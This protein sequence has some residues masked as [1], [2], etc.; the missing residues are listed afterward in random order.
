MWLCSHFSYY[1]G[2]I[3]LSFW[4]HVEIIV[5]SFWQFWNHFGIMFYS[6]LHFCAPTGLS[7][8]WY[9]VPNILLLSWS[10]RFTHKNKSNQ[11][12][13]NN[14][15]KNENHMSTSIFQVHQQAP[16]LGACCILLGVVWQIM[17]KIKRLFGI[18]GWVIAF[19]CNQWL[20]MPNA[21]SET[22]FNT[23]LG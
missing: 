11:K 16:S 19:S 7:P 4:D 2:I 18:V 6:I 13:E 1:F 10:H 22:V 17:Y 5:C 3:L 12:V 20:V 14:L 15:T 8:Y 21:Y 23:I 9:L